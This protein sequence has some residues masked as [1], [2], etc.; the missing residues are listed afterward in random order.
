MSN[1]DALSVPDRAGLRQGLWQQVN[2][3]VVGFVQG[4]L[5]QLLLSEQQRLLAAGWNERADQRRGHRNGFY[6]RGLITP[7][8]TLAIRV[9]RCR[10]TPLDCGMLFAAYQRRI[11]DV[12]RVLRHAYLLGASTRGTA[13]LIEQLF[14]GAVSHQTVSRAMRWLDDQ[15]AAWRAAPIQPVY[16][17]VYIDGMHVDVL[18]GDRMV[19]LAA[20]L[21]AD[22]RLD[23]LGFDVQPGEQCTALLADLRRRGLE[24]VELFVSDQ[25]AAIGAALAAVY[26]EVAH[27]HCTFHRLKAL[28]ETIGDRPYRDPMVAE[29]ACIFRCPS[30]QAAGD[31]AAA[32]A[33]RWRGVNRWAVQQFISGLEDSLLFYAMDQKWWRRIRTNNPL[34]RLIRTLRMRLDPMGCFHDIPA[35]ERAVFGQLARWHRLGTYTQ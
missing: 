14:G 31:A 2:Q 17:V 9:P 4:L 13:E 11:E 34:E 33:D 20:G 24:G 7:H 3:I 19:M 5:E 35:V 12:D 8:G 18:G 25:S 27:Q 10:D 28:R 26:P 6:R 16:K 21:R 29:A 32:W 22:N 15:L 1:G 23:V 30:R